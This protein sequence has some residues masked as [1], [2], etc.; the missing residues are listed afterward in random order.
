MNNNASS[1]SIGMRLLALQLFT[2]E[3]EIQFNNPSGPLIRR[4]ERQGFC[5]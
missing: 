3:K 5:P 1:F 2:D 4:N